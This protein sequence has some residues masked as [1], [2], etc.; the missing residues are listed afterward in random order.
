MLG[1][2]H[3]KNNICFYALLT[4]GMLL[5]HK[6]FIYTYSAALF[7]SKTQLSIFI[8]NGDTCDLFTFSVGTNLHSL[9]KYPNADKAY[10]TSAGCFGVFLQKFK[11]RYVGLIKLPSGS[12]NIFS[13]HCFATKGVL[14][15]KENRRQVI[16]QAGRNRRMGRKSTVRGVAQNPVDHP[17]GGGEGKKSPPS[18]K[19]TA[20]GKMLS[21]CK[22]SN[23]TLIKLKYV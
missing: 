15:N 17:H 13:L 19:R 14:C 10:I 21:W 22:T 18:C 1:A 8:N 12:I 2:F 3:F 7:D 23:S 16:G 6:A 11:R 9:E 20:W 4:D 5:G